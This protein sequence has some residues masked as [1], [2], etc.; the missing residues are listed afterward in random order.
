M[1]R[2]TKGGLAAGLFAAGL[3]VMNAV[4]TYR[5]SGASGGLPANYRWSSLVASLAAASYY[6]AVTLLLVG[7][8]VGRGEPSDSATPVAPSVPAPPPPGP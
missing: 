5:S 6:L 4:N 8:T 7:V 1:N 2:W 3:V